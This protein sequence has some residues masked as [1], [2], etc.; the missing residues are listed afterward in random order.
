MLIIDF[1]VRLKLLK[2]ENVCNFEGNSKAFAAQSGDPKP[3]RQCSPELRETGQEESTLRTSEHVLKPIKEKVSESEPKENDKKNSST[4]QGDEVCC[5]I[6]QT[7]IPSHYINTHLDKC[8]LTSKQSDQVQNASCSLGAQSTKR[9]PKLIYTPSLLPDK[10]LNRKLTD[11]GLPVTGNRQ[12]RVKR[13]Q[14]FT[15]FYNAE[16]DKENPRTKKQL[17]K[18]FLQGETEKMKSGGDSAERRNQGEIENQ[19]KARM[20]YIKE[21]NGSFKKLVDE[22]RSRKPQNSSTRQLADLSSNDQS[23]ITT[24]QSETRPNNRAKE[25]SCLMHADQDSDDF[26]DHNLLPSVKQPHSCRRRIRRFNSSGSSHSPTTDI[27]PGPS[28]D[29]LDNSSTPLAS[30]DDSLSQSI[31][32]LTGND[33][34]EM[35][36]RLSSYWY[37]KSPDNITIHAL[38]LVLLEVIQDY[39]AVTFHQS[40]T[41]DV[42]ISLQN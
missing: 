42:H 17:L 19:Q 13:H 11:L 25:R 14:E 12:I 38:L 33:D 27:N 6:C 26:E 21:H 9:L 41:V 4:T 30:D 8:L 29:L 10:E 1:W 31:L 15:L 5:P 32:N 23:S 18:E 36:V 35:M 40:I 39:K 2:L 28:A 22:I 24:S 37:F 7:L 34:S 16:C 20:A 3:S